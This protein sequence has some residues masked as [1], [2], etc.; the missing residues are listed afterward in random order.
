MASEFAN[1][2]LG[3]DKIEAQARIKE[4]SDQLQQQLQN[5]QNDAER[6][7][8]LQQIQNLPN[9]DELYANQ[10]LL[11][12]NGKLKSISSQAAQEVDTNYI[13]YLER[14]N[15]ESEAAGIA[16]GLRENQKGK[17]QGQNMGT[18]DVMAAV[19]AIKRKGTQDLVSAVKDEKELA[20]QKAGNE[21]TRRENYARTMSDD[22]RQNAI[23]KLNTY[24]QNQQYE[25][26]LTQAQL[27]NLQQQFENAPD[28]LLQQL[29]TAAASMGAQALVGL[30]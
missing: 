11:D 9:I 25:L 4:L 14:K 8:L 21:A 17:L 23:L 7:R 16:A 30:L 18:A 6:R 3:L 27:N 13:N 12:E 19:D 10:D 28:G 29:L 2:L 1:Q 26:G 5:A 20:Y 24:L 15:K 22:Q